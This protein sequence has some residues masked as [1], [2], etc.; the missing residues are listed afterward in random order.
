MKFLIIEVAELSASNEK[1]DK[2]IFTTSVFIPGKSVHCWSCLLCL[3][4]TAFRI[5]NPLIVL[6]IGIFHYVLQEVTI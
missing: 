6:L 4:T 2:T 3:F 1:N 5:R